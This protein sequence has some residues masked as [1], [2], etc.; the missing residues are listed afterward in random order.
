MGQNHSS[1]REGSTASD[2]IEGKTDYY[3]LLGVERNATEDECAFFLPI[4]F[5]MATKED[6]R[7]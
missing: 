4:Y 3:K 5:P 2:Q 6:K 7:E 1:S